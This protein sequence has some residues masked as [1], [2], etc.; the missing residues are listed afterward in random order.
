M[1]RY[2][3]NGG[4]LPR[5][6]V[7]IPT[8]NEHKYIE[9][10]LVSIV[11]QDY[12][13]DKLE[14][15]VVDGLSE[16]DTREIAR[17]ALASNDSLHWRIL[18]NPDQVTPAGLNRGI[19]VANGEVIIRV[20]GHATVARDY[21]RRCVEVLAETGAGCV[22]GHMRPV[23]SGLLG[24]AIAAAH[25]SPFGLGAGKLHNPRH[26]GPADTVY[27]G[28]WPREVFQTV[29]MFNEGLRRNQDIEFNSRIRNNNQEVYLAKSIV[30]HYHPRSS[31]R[32]LARQHF[33][34]GQ[35]NVITQK[36]SPGA[37]SFRHFVPLVFVAS[38][39][40]SLALIPVPGA[41]L[42]ML[43]GIAGAYTLANI[44][45]AVY[46]GLTYGP[47]GSIL[48]P[49]VFATIHLSYG[50]GLLWGIFTSQRLTDL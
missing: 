9:Q 3:E 11:G 8:R 46:S 45:A 27:L 10:C 43:A 22:G 31:L 35:W 24:G 14:I 33:Q 12:P 2:V 13:A 21:V 47:S 26:E 16:D 41:G 44:A 42:R 38:L 49:V 32:S 36:H 34:T 40:I 39:L 6:S 1:G 23:G 15:I 50:L 7:I 30:V 18:T 25:L 29:G 37:L 5:V 48:L 20:D 28:C 19:E 17:R 4:Q